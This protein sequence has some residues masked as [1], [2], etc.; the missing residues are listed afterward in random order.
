MS[1][2]FSGLA[3]GQHRKTH[4]RKQ[5]LR[6]FAQR[7]LRYEP[8]FILAIVYTFWLADANRLWSLLLLPPLIVLRLL[9]YRRIVST[10]PLN[11]VL[12]GLLFLGV[13]NIFI[14][15]YT[16][17]NTLMVFVPMNWETAIPWAWVMLGRPLMGCAV[18]F[19]CVE[20]SRRYGLRG[21][22][23]YT[24]VLSVIV[25][26]L[27]LVGSQWN[28]KSTQF[29]FFIQK[30]PQLRDIWLAPG[31]FNANE[32][33]GGMVWL[34]PACAGFALSRWPGR[35]LRAG[36]AVAFGL[37]LMA[38]FLGQSR[39][40][41]IG[42][43]A[44]LAVVSVLLTRSWRW[45]LA[46]LFGVAVLA[47]LQIAVSNF[48]FAPDANRNGQLMETRDENSTAARLEMYE[49]VVQILQDHPLTGVGMNMYRDGQV[50]A[51]YPVPSYGKVVLPHA[52]NEFLQLGADF[53]I[54]GLLLYVALYGVTAFMVW[55]C[56]RRGDWPARVVVVSAAAG[57]LAHG[58]YG[59]GDAVALWDRFI[60]VFWG[61]LGLIGAQYVVTTGKA[62]PIREAQA[63]AE[64]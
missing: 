40:A 60:F 26:L 54:P 20:H 18:Y 2:A 51:R 10:T 35:W 64:R 59:M 58:I 27:A 32:V 4:L 38:L 15:P 52:H 37:L 36:S 3:T 23:G 6:L 33:A 49:S 14:A 17:G 50:R 53:G 47:A 24:V 57:L 41:I 22:I 1:S 16:R 34:A 25:A 9:A 7:V 31:G 55:R 61:L 39:L 62:E 19:A 28:E 45:R 44:G 8:L 42:L 30:L 43:L 21:L 56:W 48:V 5:V 11:Y 12:A 63:T 29:S 13:L 46:A